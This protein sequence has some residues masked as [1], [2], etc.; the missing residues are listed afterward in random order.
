M[1]FY[2]L[3]TNKENKSEITDFVNILEGSE[4]VTETLKNGC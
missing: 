4:N 2:G 1:N 3:T